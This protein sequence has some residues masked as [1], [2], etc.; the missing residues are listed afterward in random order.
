MVCVGASEYNILLV[1]VYTQYAEDQAQ[2]HTF[3]CAL[4]ATR[5]RNILC[6]NAKACFRYISEPMLNAIKNKSTD[7]FKQQHTGH[8]HNCTTQLNT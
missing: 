1:H 7:S 6:G 2:D 3:S 4:H 5:K 8:L